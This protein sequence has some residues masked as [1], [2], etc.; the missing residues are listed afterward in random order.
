MDADPDAEFL[1]RMGPEL[2]L[3]L[4]LVDERAR[5]LVLGAVARA[6]GD[7][8]TG[9]VARVAGVSWQTVADGAAELESGLTAPRGRV[10]RAGGGRKKLAETDPGLRPALLALVEESVRGDPESPLMW[11]AKSVRHL[12]DELGRLGHR[13]SPQ[14]AWRL[15]RGEGFSLQASAKV[16]EGKK[17]HPD[18]DAQFRYISALAQERMAAGEPVISVDAKKKEAVGEF[19]QAGREWAPEGE[20]VPV[21]DHSF[22]DEGGHAIPYGI[23]DLAANAGFV[24][25]GTGGNT[26][27][28]A[29]AS[30]RRWHEMIGRNAYPRARRLLITCDA[31]GSNGWANR[32]WK[33]GLAALAQETG[34]EVTVCHFPPGTSKWNKIEHRLFSQI[35]HAWRG[36][37]LTSYQVII[38]TISAVTTRTGL[39]V[40]AAAGTTPCPAGVEVSDAEIAGIEDRCLTRHHFHGDW[41]YALEPVP[42]PATPPPP[43]PPPRGWPRDALTHPAL[44]G[45]SPAALGELQAALE[46]PLTARREHDLTTARGHPRTRNGGPATTIPARDRILAVLIGNHLHIPQKELAPAFG[47]AISTLSQVT[48]PVRQTLAALPAPPPCNPAPSGPPQTTR[49]LA[50]YTTLHTGIPITWPPPAPPQTPR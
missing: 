26:A 3:L 1:E 50:A 9:R 6:A 4:P 12:S 25:A 39:T 23:Y 5:R 30:V 19:A 13:C 45:I 22:E 36:R 29:V 46:L 47:I 35:S 10:R 16:K 7:G 48:K 27:A 31:G 17:R 18:R 40:T 37:P 38:D 11:T 8:G 44:T 21:R 32:A 20:P 33:K 49:E 14:T 28:L 34:L 15:L 43:A 41:N 24:N 2:G 42:R